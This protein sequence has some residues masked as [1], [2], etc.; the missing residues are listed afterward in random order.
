LTDGETVKNNGTSAPSHAAIPQLAVGENTS[1]PSLSWDSQKL[2]EIK[3]E[4]LKQPL[5][6]TAKEKRGSYA[7]GLIRLEGLLK[8][9][10]T[11][12]ELSE[13]ALSMKSMPVDEGQFGL[14]GFEGE[15][16]QAMVV[17]LLDN[18]DRKSLVDL[19][20]VHCPMRIGLSIDIEFAIVLRG[21]TMND[22]IRVLADAYGKATDANVRSD[23][24]AALRRGFTGLGVIGKDDTDFIKNAMKWYDDNKGRLEVSLEYVHNHALDDP[25]IYAKSPLFKLTK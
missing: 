16:L 9:K 12:K 22:P 20:S 5:P 13:V 10:L 7:Q 25:K 15:L 23:I 18:G 11:R 21:K 8:A 14:G 3:K 17:D 2:Q 19:L 4:W 1:S 24:A 6:K